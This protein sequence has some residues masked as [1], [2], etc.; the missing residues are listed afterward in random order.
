MLWGTWLKTAA[1]CNATLWDMPSCERTQ[2]DKQSSHLSWASVSPSPFPA[3]CQLFSYSSG[4]F[5]NDGMCNK[6]SFLSNPAPH[7]GNQFIGCYSL[8][9]PSQCGATEYSSVF[10]WL[11]EEVPGEANKLVMTPDYASQRSPKLMLSRCVLSHRQCQT[12]VFSGPLPDLYSRM[13]S[14]NTGC[15]GVQPSRSPAESLA[16]NQIQFGTNF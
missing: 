3:L 1:S 11:L 6:Y 7:Y 10:P 14:F 13:S 4:S 15:Q 8:L 12:L 5:S 9:A 16:I 2:W